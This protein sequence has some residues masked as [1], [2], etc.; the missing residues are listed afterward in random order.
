MYCFH[1]IIIFIII[2]IYLYFILKHFNIYIIFIKPPFFLIMTDL[3]TYSKKKNEC[4]FP[5]N[6]YDSKKSLKVAL[7]PDE[8]ID[9]NI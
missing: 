6:F 9:K 3:Y 7:L 5:I 2:S 1:N 4:G 8:D